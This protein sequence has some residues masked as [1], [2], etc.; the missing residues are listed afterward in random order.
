MK[1]LQTVCALTLFVFFSQPI[2]ADSHLPPGDYLFTIEHDGYV[3]DYELHVPADYSG[4]PVPLVVDFHAWG[5]TGAVQRFGSGFLQRSDE[6][7][8]LAAWPTGLERSWNAGGFCCG[9]AAANDIDDV[10]FARAVVADIAQLTPIDPTRVYATGASNGGGLSHRLACEATDVFAAV[11]PTAFVLQEEPA[12]ECHPSRPITV[13]HFHG[14]NDNTVAYDGSP[15]LPGAVDSFEAWAAINECN[16]SPERIV[17]E[18]DSYCDAYSDCADGVINV[19][20]SVR[21]GHWVYINP[22]LDVP[23]IAWGLLEGFALPS[24]PGPVDD[25]ELAVYEKR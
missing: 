14:L 10:G 21:S 17:S 1:T 25:A 15:L 4:E 9:Y 20:C 23:D 2:W 12:F 7:G 22:D 13:V 11:A 24:N 19:L 8:F 3:R 18:G 16:G 6:E 5:D